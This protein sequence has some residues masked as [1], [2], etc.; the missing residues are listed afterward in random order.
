[1]LN[2][3]NKCQKDLNAEVKW[4]NV[5]ILLLNICQNSLSIV[6]YKCQSA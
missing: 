3:H 5:L 6:V 2:Y 1:M 4:K